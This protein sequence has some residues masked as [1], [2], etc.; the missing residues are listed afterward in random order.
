MK[1]TN[2]QREMLAHRKEIRQQIEQ[3]RAAAGNSR[4]KIS[5]VTRFKTRQQARREATSLEYRLEWAPYL[6]VPGLTKAQLAAL[7]FTCDVCHQPLEIVKDGPTGSKIV[8]VERKA[9]GY[10][11][12]AWPMGVARQ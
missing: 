8:H 10:N 2:E 12:V 5:Q 9:A 11:H 1:L 3:L 7:E 6:Q 4:A